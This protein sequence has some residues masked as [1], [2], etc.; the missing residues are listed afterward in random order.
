MLVCRALHWGAMS[1]RRH[2]A[3]HPQQQNG[4]SANVP[5]TLRIG[6][7]FITLAVM[8]LLLL[9]VQIFTQGWMA[10]LVITPG[11]VLIV[12]AALLLGAFGGVRSG[13]AASR[14]RVIALGLAVVMVLLSRLLQ[15][16]VLMVMDQYWII[17][18]AG[19]ALLAGLWLRRSVI[20]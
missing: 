5:M 1:Q 9:F 10:P 2:S 14:S 18:Y 17:M 15:S 11:F 19:I 12:V 8:L 20:P 13:D 3:D 16:P 6:G 7:A 4:S